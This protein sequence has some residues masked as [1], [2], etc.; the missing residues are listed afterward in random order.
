MTCL[1]GLAHASH[2]KG[3]SLTWKKDT[4]APDFVIDAEVII[5][6][7]LSAGGTL[8][9]PVTPTPE[10]IRKVNG[11]PFYQPGD[12]VGSN[13]TLYWGADEGSVDINRFRVVAVDPAAQIVTAKA[14]ETETVDLSHEYEWDGEDYFDL[15]ISANARD[16]Q[17][18]L[19]NRTNTD[20]LIESRVTQ[21]VN[22][23]PPSFSATQSSLVIVDKGTDLNPVVTFQAPVATDPDTGDTV[24]YS[25]I[26]HESD[27]SNLNYDGNDTAWENLPA[28]GMSITDTGLISWDTS[29]IDQTI[30][31]YCIQVV[32]KDYALGSTQPKSSTTLEFQ[33]W[34]DD[35]EQTGVPQ[36]VLSPS[37]SVIHVHPGEKAE[38]AIIGYDHGENSRLELIRGGDA[39]PDGAVLLPT[40]GFA[41]GGHDHEDEDADDHVTSYFSWTPTSAELGHEYEMTFKFRD[42]DGLE[43]SVVTTTVIVV[44]AP[45]TPLEPLELTVT[46]VIYSP[47]SL[48]T[49]VTFSV[50]G[51]CATPGLELSLYTDNALPEGAEFYP[52]LPVRGPG[53]VTSTFT[54]QADPGYLT[55][56]GEPVVINMLLGDSERRVINKKVHLV[57]GPP[58]PVVTLAA[59]TTV[60]IPATMWQTLIVN[61]NATGGLDHHTRLIFDAENAGT[62]EEDEMESP[63]AN[64]VIWKVLPGQIQNGALRIRV[65]DEW[66]GTTVLAVPITLANPGAPAWWDSANPAEDVLTGG[67]AVDFG[68]A[69][70]GQLKA[71]ASRAYAQ[72]AVEFPD[73]ATATDEGIAL[74]AYVSGFQTSSGNYEPLLQGQLKHAATL[75]Y[76]AI[77]A[78]TGKGEIGYPWAKNIGDDRNHSPATVGQ[79]KLAFSFPQPLLGAI[80]NEPPNSVVITSPTQGQ[81]FYTLAEK[82]V[83]VQVAASDPDGDIE[84]VEF[85]ENGVLF[86]TDT[87]AP[88]EAVFE[89]APLG[90]YALTAKAIDSHDE[91]LTSSAVSVTVASNA[92]SSVSLVGLTEGAH[93]PGWTGVPIRVDVSDPDDNIVRVDIWQTSGSFGTRI[94]AIFL[95]PSVPPYEATWVDGQ[96][97]YEIWAIAYDADGQK[98][99]SEHIHVVRD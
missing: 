86:A 4:T 76:D 29:Q 11:K 95:P 75:F 82:D 79:V 63:A 46:D 28:T 15:Q 66:G 40:A 30:Q 18:E 80:F 94:V 34:V 6:F 54:W 23:T 47:D 53:V 48:G 10:N 90:T 32:A 39:L 20:M 33:V 74:A 62:V 50:T 93:Y 59:G 73:I 13:V 70:Q 43:S 14:I 60:P 38:F 3:G 7:D 89:D 49:E 26:A 97:T 55:H 31:T 42:E 19:A 27:A 35:T 9:Y 8:L 17:E 88:Y 91:E 24:K 71:I 37:T 51:T 96:D 69:N 41:G 83:T 99:E 45:T 21:A 67:A 65:I 61:F 5:N 1:T 25:F 92:P 72:L 78:A 2:L 56:P 44:T 85:Y 58:P 22:N 12:I 81:H 87:T 77:G 68:M 64:R 84:R 36:I 98:L 57:I 16:T 52:V